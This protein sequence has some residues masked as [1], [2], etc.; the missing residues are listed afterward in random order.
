MTFLRALRARYGHAGIA[1]RLALGFGVL[2]LMMTAVVGIA[3]WQASRMERQL[4]DV[5][6]VQLP[7]MIRVDALERLVAELNIAARDAIVSNGEPAG[8]KALARIESGRVQVG[9]QIEDLQ[10]ALHAIGQRGEKSAVELGDQ[11]SGILIALVKFGRVLKTHNMDMARTVLTTGVQPRIQELGEAVDRAQALQLQMLEEARGRSAYAARMAFIEI[12]V[13][14]MAAMAVAAI[15]AWRI[16]VSVTR[17]VQDAV[18]LAERIAAGDLRETL[19][20]DRRDELGRMQQALATMQVHLSRLVGQIRDVAI[21]MTYASAEVASGSNDL[22]RRTELAASTLQEAASSMNQLTNRVRENADAAHSAN[23]LAANAAEVAQRGGDVVSKVVE[24]MSDISDASRRIAEITGVIDGISF[25]T[26]ILA[27][28]AA[29]EAARAGEHGRGFAVVAGEVRGLA[30]RA[31][32]ASHE[33]KTLIASSVKKVDSGCELVQAAGGTMR[34]IVSGARE[35]TE[36]ISGISN[37]S[38]RQSGDLDCVNVT[39]ARLDEMTQ[40]NSAL[41]EQ[42]AAAAENMREQ[43]QRLQGMVDTFKIPG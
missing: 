37:A 25:Q 18:L 38:D 34:D 31:A 3:A 13:A 27:L 19:T 20:V 7:R 11:S 33:I 40:Q 24:N 39:V 1:R 28:N 32:T 29:V 8:D 6:N 5:I 15:L 30:Q 17:P 42:S 4:D 36:L 21:Q 12:G 2:V 41:V 9:Q 16:S 23:A 14:L 26:N 22:S 10:Q 35:V 43:S